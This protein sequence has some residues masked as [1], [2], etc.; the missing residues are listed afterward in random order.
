MTTARTITFFAAAMLLSPAGCADDPIY[1]QPGTALEVGGMS[2]GDATA[3][4]M[5]PVRLETEVEAQDRA[6]LEAEL[7]TMVPLVRR[8]DLD[9]S[10]EWNV[11]NLD[12]DNSALFFLSLNGANEYFAYNPA[13]FVVDPEEDEEPPPLAGGIPTE[14]EAGATMSGVF[15]EDDL[16]EA[17]HDL[18]LITRGAINPFTA[19]LTNNEDET[20]LDAAGILIPLEHTAQM[21]RFDIVFSSGGNL[22]L[23]YAARVRDHRDPD[24]LHDE[25]QFADPAELVMFAPADFVPPPPVAP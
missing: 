25:L 23:E 1:V 7:G 14:I 8:S 9:I 13:A 3:Q 17:A 20:E 2:P 15:R 12:P 6:R 4:L 5:L 16:L 19:L 22:V 10:I 11:R 24:L 21:V 18:E